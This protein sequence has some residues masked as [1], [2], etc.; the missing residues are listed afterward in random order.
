MAEANGIDVRKPRVAGRQQHRA[1]S[2]SASDSICDYYR[3]NLTIPIIDAVL[4]SM[5]ER[6]LHGQDVIYK[7]FFLLPSQVRKKDWSESSAKPFIDMFIDDLPD[8]L[9]LATELKMWKTL[10]SDPSRAAVVPKTLQETMKATDQYMYQNIKK[11]LQILLTIPVTSCEAERAISGLR[12]LKNYMRST[13][14]QQRFTGLALMH[15]HHSMDIDL[16]NIIDE[17][18]QKHPRRMRLSNILK[19]D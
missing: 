18:C 11:L 19:D 5:Q 15:I 7:G 10:W 6:F 17:F 14:G 8:P 9:R 1:N 13:M 2:G 16:D 12:L 3:I 4:I